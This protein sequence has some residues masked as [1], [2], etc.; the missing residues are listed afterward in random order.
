[1]MSKEREKQTL[2]LSFSVPL[3]IFVLLFVIGSAVLV[4]VFASAAKISRQAKQKND[5]IQ[6]CRN[7]MEIYSSCADLQQTAAQLGGLPGQTE[8]YFDRELHC[9]QQ[10]Q[11]S[12]VL[13]LQDVE[14]DSLKNGSFSVSNLEQEQLYSLSVDVYVPEVSQ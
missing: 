10:T 3:L 12:Y 6:I 9:V 14:Q 13:H 4:S 8:L 11:A 1:M 7:A 5:A 2:S